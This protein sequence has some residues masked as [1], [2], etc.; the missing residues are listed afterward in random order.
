MTNVDTSAI[1][2]ETDFEKKPHL[3]LKLVPG[4]VLMPLSADDKDEEHKL[5]IPIMFTPR[6][7]RAYEETV[8][9]DFNNLYKVDV[10]IKGEGIPLQL[11]LQDAD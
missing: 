3:D 11:E 6:D 8:S 2:I 7:T 10:V 1:S 4:K 5:E 9:F